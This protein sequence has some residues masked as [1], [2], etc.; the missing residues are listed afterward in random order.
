M[1]LCR[2]AAPAHRCNCNTC[3]L[4]LLTASHTT[5]P[6]TALSRLR[7]QPYNQSA[8]RLSPTP[9]IYLCLAE[10]G[11][12]SQ[13][14]GMMAAKF[15]ADRS[16]TATG[17][18]WDPFG[19]AAYTSVPALPPPPGR[20]AASPS[21]SK[22]ALPLTPLAPP[23]RTNPPRAPGQPLPHTPPR[24]Q[25][26]AAGPDGGAAGSGT[27]NGGAGGGAAHASP[28]TPASGTK[29]QT[30]VSSPD[31]SS[32]TPAAAAA[33]GDDPTDPAS[34]SGASPSAPTAAAAAAG[35]G[36]DGDDGASSASTPAPKAAAAGA[37]ADASA[38]SVEV[39]VP[40]EFV[41]PITHQVMIDPVIAA[42]GRW[43]LARTGAVGSFLA[44]RLTCLGYQ[45]ALP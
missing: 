31:G 27:G 1:V 29:P 26:A 10:G 22:T 36:G 9:P 44:G 32:S 25:A 15:G 39:A 37:A 30:G 2:R 19:T 4:L 6:P 35:G 40:K 23:P 21:P 38:S 14:S 17:E 41:C 5:T 43:V 3:H 34:A 13:R 33:S 24:P 20:K 45:V 18:A 7:I 42:D 11:E 8:P 16:A 28:A 12:G